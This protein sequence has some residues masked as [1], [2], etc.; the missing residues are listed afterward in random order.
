[1]QEDIF[2]SAT[3]I[4]NYFDK[5]NNNNKEKLFKEYKNKLEKL[6]QEEKR[7]LS[8]FKKDIKE[9]ILENIKKYMEKYVDE[10]GSI[11]ESLMNETNSELNEMLLQA[12]ILY[13]DIQLKF[14]TYKFD[15]LNNKLDSKISDAETST[16][17]LM[18]NVI[19]I[20]LGISI[21]NAM[22]S[23]IELVNSEF[24]LFY[25]LSC[26]WIALTILTIS[27]LLLKRIDKRTNIVLII[28]IIFSIIWIAIGLIS[29]NSYQ[30][31]AINNNEKTCEKS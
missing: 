28:Y 18:F 17:S 23:G 11:E 25:F 10:I 16:T 2:K 15:D 14:V 30:K 7:S 22:I 21:T 19:S 3:L 31:K 24:I 9:S 29:Y 12:N 26:A 4:S 6:I 1:M 27:T 5:I 20:F 13:R 8:Y